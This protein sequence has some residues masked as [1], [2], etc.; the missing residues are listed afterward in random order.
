M[1]CA[2]DRLAATIANRTLMARSAT[3]AVIIALPVAT[4]VAGIWTLKIAGSGGLDTVSDPVR[5]TAQVQVVD[6]E[7]D[8]AARLLGLSAELHWASGQSKLVPV[9][10]DASAWPSGLTLRLEHPLREALDTDIALERQDGQWVGS[11]F[12]ASVGWRVSVLPSNGSWRLVGRWSRGAQTLSMRS[13]WD[14]SEDA[15][16][17]R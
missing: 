2:R 10:G 5:R 16:G 4:L 13:A 11:G 17:A 14:P 7:A 1:G 9:S 12:D 3:L 15:G 6:A 8:E